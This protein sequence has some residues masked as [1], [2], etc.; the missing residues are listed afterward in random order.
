M[1]NEIIDV[2]NSTYS[3]SVPKVNVGTYGTVTLSNEVQ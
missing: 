3:A 1:A 2:I